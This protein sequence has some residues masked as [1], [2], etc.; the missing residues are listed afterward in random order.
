A[1]VGAALYQLARTDEIQTAAEDFA[2]LRDIVSFANKVGA[3]VCTKIGAIDAL[4]SLKEVE[5]SL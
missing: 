5:V 4:P 2:K 3:L 1:F